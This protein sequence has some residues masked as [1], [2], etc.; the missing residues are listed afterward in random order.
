MRRTLVTLQSTLAALRLDPSD[1]AC[2]ESLEEVRAKMRMVDS[3]L[4]GGRARATGAP[5]SSGTTELSF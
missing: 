4:K 5:Q 2:F 3:W 1:A